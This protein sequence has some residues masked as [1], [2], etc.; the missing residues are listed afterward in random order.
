MKNKL[1]VSENINYN[2]F[3][4]IRFLLALSVIFCHSYAIY[5]GWESFARNEFFMKWTG[6]KISIGS[7]A[8]NF[9]FVISGFLIVRSF[10]YSKSFWQYLKKRALRIYPG[11]IVVFFLS[12]FAFGPLGHMKEFSIEAYLDFLDSVW[13][14]R[15]V[16]NMISLQAP[17]EK[18]YFTQLPQFGLNNS[19]WTIQ[20]E[21]ICY[22]AVPV[23]AWIGFTK[24]RKLLLIALII[25]H[26]LLGLQS[27]G[28]IFPFSEKLSG[29]II[30]NP[31]Y[32]PRFFTYFLLGACVYLFKDS[33]PRNF[34]IAAL[35]AIIFLLGF[36][37][38]MV[39]ILWPV[40]GTYL[41]FY[42]A[43]HPKL[44]FPNFAKHGDLSYGIYLYGWPLQQLVMVYLGSY[45]DA[46]G[47]FLVVTPIVIVFAFISWKLIESPA[48][49]L[50]NTNFFE[51][52]YR[53][54]PMITD[55]LKNPP[56]KKAS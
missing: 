48:L 54:I 42:F 5:L 37:F 41:L 20:Y 55:K 45:L 33:L 9:F 32:Y 3:D 10:K 12:I 36:K 43:Y 22:L 35:A 46:K 6:G 49:Q 47:L 17:I 19:L 24:H 15:E 29:G 31:Y 39:D 27:V 38:Q 44:I 8:V 28:Y 50:K 51:I 23:L 4:L 21:F 30:S 7:T 26:V 52:N 56:N 40:S 25:S 11:F 14:K 34:L 16:A 1:L 13:I 2:N 18:N 53:I